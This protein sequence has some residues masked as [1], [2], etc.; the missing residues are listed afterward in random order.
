M[1]KKAGLVTIVFVICMVFLLPAAARKA[2]I[3]QVTPQT[4]VKSEVS[5]L[6]ARIDRLEKELELMKRF[7]KIS[8]EDIII[9][10][11]TVRI[12]GR[13]VAVEGSLNTQIKGRAVTVQA[14]GENVIKGA[15]VRIN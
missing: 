5:E 7:I 2:Q 11:G 9:E 8:D 15:L 14:S 6:R 12:N 4:V 13:D 3:K 10:G 1:T